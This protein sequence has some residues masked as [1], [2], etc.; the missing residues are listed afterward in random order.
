M[1]HQ[2]LIGKRYHE[3]FR[4]GKRHANDRAPTFDEL[5]KISEY[6]NRRIKRI[7]Y[8]MA[9]TRVRLGAWDILQ[10]KHIEP[11]TNDEGKVVAAK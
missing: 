7:I 1:I 9:S 2:S 8:I 11:L 3:M 6:P 5:L 10:W 4:Q